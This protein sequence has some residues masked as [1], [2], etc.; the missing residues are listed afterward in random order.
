[1]LPDLHALFIQKN[2]FE[3][4]KKLSREDIE[5]LLYPHG[6]DDYLAA[7][8]RLAVLL[9]S[10]NTLRNA[11]LVEYAKLD[12]KVR[13]HKGRVQCAIDALKKLVEAEGIPFL[14]YY[15]V[16]DDQFYLIPLYTPGINM[17]I[18]QAQTRIGKWQAN[19]VL[20]ITFKKQIQR[21]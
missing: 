3:L 18:G 19:E 20:G 12:R 17:Y 16:G 8:K 11:K 1:M 6:K 15:L 2:A 10:F 4:K 7:K 14:S 9:A 5:G 21:G 13:L